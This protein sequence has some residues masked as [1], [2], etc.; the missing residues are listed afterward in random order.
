M[1]RLL[2]VA[3]CS[4]A[5]LAA[6]RPATGSIGAAP[7]GPLALPTTLK[8][9]IDA[10]YA[11]TQRRTRGT[12]GIAIADERGNVL[13]AKNPDR[14]MIPASTAKIFTTSFALSKLGGDFT[15]A[16]R[17]EGVGVLDTATGQWVGT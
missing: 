6:Q 7:P 14:A 1:K 16:T 5:P 2:L 4:A 3:L 15:H 17:V 8:R 13:W 12:W 9:R 10:W 11:T